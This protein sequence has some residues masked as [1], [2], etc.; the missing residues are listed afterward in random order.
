MGGLFDE[1]VVGQDPWQRSGEF[2]SPIPPN[3]SPT[4]AI[5]AF[6]GTTAPSGWLICDGSSFSSSNYP[7]LATLLGGTTL[8][9]LR[10]RFPMGKA[11]SG[12][13]STLGGTGGSKD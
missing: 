9:D 2:Q 10:Q 6:Y 5:M 7:A 4:G 12:T 1:N 13:G 11:A 3:T 8:P